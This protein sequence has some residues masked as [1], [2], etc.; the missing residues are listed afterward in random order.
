MYNNGY[1]LGN[2]ERQV[3]SLNEMLHIRWKVTLFPK[4]TSVYRVERFEKNSPQRKGM[5]RTKQSLHL[6]MTVMY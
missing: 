6:F 1:R 3:D 2:V 4:R 5:F